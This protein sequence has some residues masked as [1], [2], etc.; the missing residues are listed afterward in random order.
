MR[1]GG[2]L[3][4]SLLR[5]LFIFVTFLA[6]RS[7]V[8]KKDR[9][10]FTSYLPYFS[11]IA[12]FWLTSVIFFGF[13]TGILLW[14]NIVMRIIHIVA[15]GIIDIVSAFYAVT[16]F[17][18]TLLSP[19]FVFFFMFFFDSGKRPKDILFSFYHA[20]KMV[21]YNYPVCL[22]ITYCLH[23]ILEL[24]GTFPLG[25]PLI[26]KLWWPMQTYINIYP[27]FNFVALLVAPILICIFANIYIKKLHEQF[28][29]YFPQPK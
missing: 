14:N 18:F 17:N 3:L 27:L 13:H 21:L 7:S 11:Y 4:R 10:Y 1:V 8:T 25:L 28:D 22:I 23:G 9:A 5:S 19:V 24:L 20:L 26:L 16:L 12:I 15:M 6:T 29:V 2:S